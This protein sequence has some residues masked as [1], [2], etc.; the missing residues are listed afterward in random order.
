MDSRNHET[1]TFSVPMVEAISRGESLDL[2]DSD[3]DAEAVLS[4]IRDETATPEVRCPSPTPSHDVL[5]HVDDPPPSHRTLLAA[6]ARSR[7][8]VAPQRPQYDAVIARLDSLNVS[9]VNVETA[10]KRVADAGNDETRLREQ[11]ATLRGQLQARRETGADTESVTTA[12]ADTAARLSEVETERVA[13][14]QTLARQEQRAVDARE[15][16]QR[17]LELQDEAANLE[18][19]M[20]ASLAE[21]LTPVFDDAVAVVD[22]HRNFAADA[23]ADGDATE[24]GTGD[25][26]GRTSVT[27]HLAAVC[28]A[29]LR[30]PVVVSPPVFDSTRVAE[31]CLDTAVILL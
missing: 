10:R 15:M 21:Q 22:E 18:R 5:G 29:D 1:V 28:L 12:L 11:M 23:D 19:Q 13:A 7:G 16:R 26:G 31:R 30:A 24:D 2:R 20:R 14:E 6:A 8:H 17:R 25:D 9:T 3:I 4:M 27:T